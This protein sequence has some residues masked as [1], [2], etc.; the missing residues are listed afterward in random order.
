MPTQ[1]F[2]PTQTF[3]ATGSYQEN[4]DVSDATVLQDVAEK[5]MSNVAFLLGSA[6]GA[7][8]QAVRKIATVDDLAALKA[9]A[10][11]DRRDRDYCALDSNKRIYQFDSASAATGDD[12]AVVTPAAGT[13]RWILDASAVPA[14]TTLRRLSSA[15]AWTLPV[16]DITIVASGANGRILQGGGS[17]YIDVWGTEFTDLNPGDIITSIELAGNANVGGGGANIVAVFYKVVAAL[18]ATTPTVTVLG[19]L[20]IAAGAGNT[21]T[22]ANAAPLPITIASGEKI[23]VVI[24]CDTQGGAKQVY[25]YWVAINGTRSYITE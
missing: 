16:G 4:G 6:S 25:H 7:T 20:T 2:T 17:A 23:V 5:T 10:A 21:N 18:A 11:A 9:I 1:T 3:S 22:T 12:Y 14:S 19:T 24:T 13:G 8:P 15:L